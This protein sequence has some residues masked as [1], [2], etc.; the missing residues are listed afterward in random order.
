[1]GFG[2]AA[3]EINVRLSSAQRTFS[4]EGG[5]RG[6]FGESWLSVSNGFTSNLLADLS[7]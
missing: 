6:D 1:M 2:F 5:V 3:L 7:T 4:N